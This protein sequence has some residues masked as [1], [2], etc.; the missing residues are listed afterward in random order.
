MSCSLTE[1]VEPG[2]SKHRLE[3]QRAGHDDARPFRVQADD[4]APLLEGDAGE[5]LEQVGDVGAG[6]HVTVHPDAGRTRQARA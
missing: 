3:Y 5:H 1:L 4:G 2:Q 6:Q